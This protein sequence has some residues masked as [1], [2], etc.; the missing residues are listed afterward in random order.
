MR[1][2]ATSQLASLN[3][4]LVER[5]DSLDALHLG[6]GN[7]QLVGLSAGAIAEAAVP[8]DARSGPTSS[9]HARG[10]KDLEID[11]LQTGRMDSRN[12]AREQVID[13]V[14]VSNVDSLAPEAQPRD[15]RVEVV[16]PVTGPRQPTEER[17]EE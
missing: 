4:L 8:L 16:V 13:P 3:H 9:I 1:E 10:T 15:A 11:D 5:V 17:L 2:L 14:Q 6:P 7:R 12:E